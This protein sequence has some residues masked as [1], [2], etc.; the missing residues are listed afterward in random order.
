[1]EREIGGTV[2]I[3]SKSQHAKFGENTQ[4]PG[5]KKPHQQNIAISRFSMLK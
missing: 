1:V 5:R 3:I 4:T 2:I